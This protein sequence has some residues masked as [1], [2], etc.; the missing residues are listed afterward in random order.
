M[1]STDQ[2]PATTSLS[3]YDD[4]NSVERIM[5]IAEANPGLISNPDHIEVGWKLKIPGISTTTTTTDVRTPRR[6]AH[7]DRRGS[8]EAG[9][10]ILQ[11]REAAF[12]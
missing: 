3:G 5:E 8:M 9:S 4:P 7:R 10:R 6:E 11:S 1:T 12:V 2:P